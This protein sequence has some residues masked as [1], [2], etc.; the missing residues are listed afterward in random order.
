MSESPSSIDQHIMDAYETAA[1]RRPWM[2]FYKDN[3]A[4]IDSGPATALDLFRA[5]R[6]QSLAILY[7][8]GVV[9]YAALDRLSDSLAAGWAARGVTRGDRVAIVLQ[10]TPQF[11]I[12]ALAAWKLAAIPVSLNP[13]YRAAELKRLFADCTPRAA[14]CHDDQWDTLTEAAAGIIGRD[15]LAWTSG[16]EFQTR[17]DARVMPPSATAPASNDLRV[18]LAAPSKS[19]PAA[20]VSADEV[21]LLLYTSGTTGVP[22]GAM[23]THRNL[24]HNASIC[25]SLLGLGPRSR[26]FGVAPLFHV[27]GFEVQMVSAFAAQSAI[28]L[29]YRFQP[30]V[31]LEAFLEHRPTFIIG[32]ITAFIA[33]INQPEATPA[34]FASFDRLYSGGAPIAPAV[35]NA[36]AQRFGRAIRSS[37]GMT[38]LTAPCHLAPA[39]GPIPVDPNSGALSIGIPTPGTDAIVVDDA[40]KPLGPGKHGELVIRGPQVMAGYWRKRSETDEVLKGGW[41]HTGDVGF[42]DEAGWFYLVDRKKDMISASGFKVW[43][44][45]VEDVLYAYPGVREAAVVGAPDDYRGETVIAYVSAEAGARLDIER[46]A[47]YCR[48]RLAAYKCP[49]QI[50]VLGD[51]PKTATGKIMRN[52]LKVSPP[53][54]DA[55][56]GSAKTT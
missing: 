15:L 2:K 49:K 37:Y 23:L 26:I 13:M 41:M 1:R 55:A 14:V 19:A 9:D 48:E 11:V 6:K 22:K 17:C 20:Q 36:F 30:A 29:T 4:L 42:Y 28:I 32:A 21:A 44:R 47:R 34:H 24:V 50:T 10:N 45:E 53:K 39:E 8:D 35:I 31:V 5:V 12:A 52:V 7:F 56:E 38:E 51:L 46:I 18:I 43:P 54:V 3:D 33:L 40:K 25:A 16:R 27:T